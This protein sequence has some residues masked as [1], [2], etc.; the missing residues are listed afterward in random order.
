MAANVHTFDDTNFQNEVL[1]HASGPVLVD[2][3]A[4]WCGPCKVLAPIVEKLADEFQGKL[5]VGKV[6]IDVAPK[7]A[8]KYGITSVP[9]VIVF[10]NG[11]KKASMIGV[12]KRDKLV[13]MAGL[14]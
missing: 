7:I 14:R 6:D 3:H 11:A 2:F 1:D 9:T 5:K 8:Q 13:E 10:E 12:A 4:T